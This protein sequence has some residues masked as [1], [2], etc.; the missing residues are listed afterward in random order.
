MNDI[1]DRARV[2][3]ERGKAVERIAP[4]FFPKLL[5]VE[6]EH[7]ARYRWAA[8]RVRASRVLDVAC[9]TG[10]GAGLL[11]EGGAQ[12]VVSVECSADALRFG[13]SRYGLQAVRADAHCLPFGESCYDV[14]VCFETI[15]HLAKPELF[16]SEVNRILRQNGALFIS[17]PNAHRS[18]GDNPYH[19]REFTFEELTT[20]VL[21]A[22]LDVESVRG[23]HWRLRGSTFEKVRGL[24]RLA[25]EFERRP[26]V[27]KFPSAFGEPL[28]WCVVAQKR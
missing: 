10:Y 15:E 27:T 8:K 22:G 11:R 7:I 19:I 28:Y 21:R 18:N 26:V 2:F 23:Q 17:T 3:G 16:L 24:R 4:G 25:F 1:V 13:A 9:G 14:V 5:E 6:K 12:C 20:F